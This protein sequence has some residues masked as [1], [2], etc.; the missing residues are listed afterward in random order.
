M[1]SDV[2]AAG[3]YSSVAELRAALAALP[4]ADPW[5][6]CNGHDLVATLLL[7]L[8]RVLGSVKAS[9]GVDHRQ[10]NGHADQRHA[11][12]RVV[13][14][15]NVFVSGWINP[16]GAPGT[17]VDA[18]IEGR[19]THVF[20]SERTGGAPCG[21]IAG[22]VPSPGEGTASR[23]AAAQDLRTNACRL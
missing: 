12:V 10:A 15:T 20:S 22:T 21:P 8:R 14:D 16:W 11:G 23:G 18:V 6:V 3:A 9:V 1:H 5:L 19:I 4:Q 13:V 7:G 2:V 17:I